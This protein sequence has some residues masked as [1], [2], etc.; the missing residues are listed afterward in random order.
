M[1]KVGPLYHMILAGDSPKGSNLSPTIMDLVSL[2]PLSELKN[3]VH[4]LET[5]RLEL[6]LRSASGSPADISRR[7]INQL[8]DIPAASSG[9]F[10]T[11]Y[12]I[13][14]EYDGPFHRP[15]ALDY[16][17]VFLGIVTLTMEDGSQV[18]LE[19]LVELTMR[20]GFLKVAAIYGLHNI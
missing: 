13:P 19:A 6:P 20:L 11:T 15:V 9:S 4:R 7:P 16:V 1:E 12:D 14:P 18:T 3:Q 2:Q 8:P 10:F 17:L 5:A